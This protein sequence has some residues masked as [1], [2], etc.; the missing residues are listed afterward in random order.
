MSHHELDELDGKI[1]KLIVNN[2]RIPLLTI[3][4]AF[5]SFT[6][7]LLAIVTSLLAHDASTNTL[8]IAL[9]ISLFCILS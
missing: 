4:S 5:A 3:F 9:Y 8:M 6:K 7:L 2:A 1:L